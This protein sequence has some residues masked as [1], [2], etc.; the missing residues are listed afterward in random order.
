MKIEDAMVEYFEGV[1]SNDNIQIDMDVL[2]CPEHL[3]DYVEGWRR[4][5]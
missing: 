4:K 5:L 2:Q 1:V 3:A